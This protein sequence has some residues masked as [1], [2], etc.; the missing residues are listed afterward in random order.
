MQKLE[1]A[2]AE[3]D[4]DV[5]VCGLKRKLRFVWMLHGRRWEV[6]NTFGLTDARR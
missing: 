2:G 4:V 5:D 6:G 3:A 1:A